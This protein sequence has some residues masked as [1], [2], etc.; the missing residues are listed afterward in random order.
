MTDQNSS[1][2]AGRRIERFN[3]GW[4]FVPDGVGTD[5]ES[6]A[7]PHT[8]NALDGQ[9]GGN[10]YRRGIGTYTKRFD[11]D[12]GDDEV[13]LE[14]AGANSSADV[15][16]NGTH[17]AH[18]DGGYSTFRCELTP[19]LEPANVLT[20]VV[21]NAPNTTIYPQR[22]DFT[23][24]GGIYRG[25]T[26]ITV[27]R[28]HFVLDDHG[29]PGV[30]FTPTLDGSRAIVTCEASATGG[31][32]VRFAVDGADA[33]TASVVAGSARADIVIDDVRRWHG[34]RDPHLYRVTA[35]LLAGDD[36]VDEV[37]L[38]VGCR[39]FAIDPD[40]GFLLNG[41][42]YPLRGVSRHQDWE[43]VGNAITTDMM[44]T[45]LA[46]IQ[47]IGATTVR[48][49]HYQHDQHFY[50]LC[51]AAGIV[52]WAEIPQITDFLPAGTENAT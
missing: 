34:T 28:S 42:P 25:V 1:H 23:F 33:Q 3:D 46:L 9:D 14:F 30:V 4:H 18:H 39:E 51:D 19:A 27:P 12:A 48:L 11:L 5:G 16:L 45:D 20:V 32:A 31:D 26:L 41:E 47:E 15:Y 2:R 38:R 50:D 43:G 6:V 52:V 17:L 21:D 22:A 35:T 37:S 36:V 29:G 49:A 44:Q 7:L 10:D 13:W 24:Y 40:R 8:W